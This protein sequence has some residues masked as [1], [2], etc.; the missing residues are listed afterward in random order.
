VY[1]FS[2]DVR[3]LARKIK[4]AN[5]KLYNAAV[6]L[7][8]TTIALKSYKNFKTCGVDQSYEELMQK[9][10][11]EFFGV[12]KNEFLDLDCN[13]RLD[14][15]S[16]VDSPLIVTHKLQQKHFLDGPDLFDCFMKEKKTLNEPV[17]LIGGQRSMIQ[18][19]KSPEDSSEKPQLT[20]NSSKGGG[21]DF[22]AIAMHRDSD[23]SKL[24]SE[25]QEAYVSAMD[26]EEIDPNSEGFSAGQGGS[27]RNIDI[28]GEGSPSEGSDGKIT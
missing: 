14:K 2:D 3:I 12:K 24:S 27:D 28:L 10:A 23:L 5:D 21:S 15:K 8:A 16:R 19:Y 1:K 26:D 6:D 11:P 7:K 18:S 13:Q 9:V 17:W 4:K 20:P 25:S 22:A